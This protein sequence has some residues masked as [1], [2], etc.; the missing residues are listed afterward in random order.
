MPASTCF[1]DYAG[2]TVPIDDVLNGEWH[3][4]VIFAAG[5]GAS[6]YFFG[7]ASWG[8]DVEA[9]VN[10][11]VRAFEYFG[12]VVAVLV[13]HFVPGHRIR[14][15]GL[16]PRAEMLDLRAAGWGHFR[17]VCRG[18]VEGPLA[19]ILLLRDRVRIGLVVRVAPGPVR[20]SWHHPAQ[21]RGLGGA[22]CGKSLPGLYTGTKES[23]DILRVKHQAIAGRFRMGLGA[24]PV[25]LIPDSLGW[26]SAGQRPA[27]AVMPQPEHRPD[28]ETSRN[29][30]NPKPPGAATGRLV[31][32][33]LVVGCGR[34]WR[35][36]LWFVAVPW[37]RQ[38]FT[39]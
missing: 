25:E 12:G 29:R 7:E 8:Q 16:Q 3:E 23:S 13:P 6:S 21:D 33:S 35:L 19:E 27:A 20:R 18:L 15:V 28:T 11:H 37:L 36:L 24:M 22:R 32:R 30:A 1:V 4:A 2:Q 34:G 9:W 10:S 5:L 31:R 38:R 17:R 26:H 39:R 14:Q